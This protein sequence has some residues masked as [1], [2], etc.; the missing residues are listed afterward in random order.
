MLVGSGA[1]GT[2]S[3]LTERYP[4]LQQICDFTVKDVDLLPL[5]ARGE[6]TDSPD[7]V[8][9]CHP[10]EDD[11][12]K[13]AM[14]MERLWRGRSPSIVVWLDGLETFIDEGG[15]RPGANLLA[16]GS[17]VLRAFGVVAAACDPA[18]IREDLVERFAHVIHDRYRQGRRQHGE[19]SPDDPSLAPWDRLS[20]RLQRASRAQAEDIGRKL[21]QVDCAIVPRFGRD[22][23]VV[24]SES[25][26]ESLAQQEHTRWCREYEQAGWR[27][28]PQRSE[29]RKLHPGLRPWCS[30]PRHFQRR[31]CDA[32]RELFDILSDAG[33]RVVRG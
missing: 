32:I 9:V 16:G 25:D 6:I 11:A 22:G 7:R 8:L 18:L 28:S 23:G 19:W 1:T 12:L 29:E 26:I 30:L 14:T 2:I 10:N 33:F 5:L 3:D 24:L 31:N 21:A 17:G 27:H 13:S 4:F 20:P 15:S